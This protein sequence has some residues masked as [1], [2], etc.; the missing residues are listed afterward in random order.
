MP[1]LL[2]K[3]DGQWAISEEPESLWET[4]AEWRPGQALLV[5]VDSEPTVEWLEASRIG[6][7]FPALTDGRGL[8]LAV[9]LRTRLNYRGDLVARGN[10]HEDIA[11]FLARCGYNVIEL[12]EHKDLNT[13]LKWIAPHTGFYQASVD[14][15][16]TVF[17]RTSG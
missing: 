13:A 10:V 6:V 5:A 1:Q 9:L 16:T 14:S 8:S 17:A 4:E 12:P 7:D 15:P 3:T 2:R 11:H